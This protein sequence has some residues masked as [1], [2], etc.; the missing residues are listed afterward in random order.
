MEV[1]KNYDTATIVQ[2][3]DKCDAF[4]SIDELKRFKS[5]QLNCCIVYCVWMET[6]GGSRDKLFCWLA[7]ICFQCFRK[8]SVY[9]GEISAPT[10]KTLELFELGWTTP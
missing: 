9:G 1:K 5:K 10:D 7:A 6:W 3:N 8:E 4:A 2:S